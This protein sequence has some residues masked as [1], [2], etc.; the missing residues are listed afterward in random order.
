[1]S[2]VALAINGGNWIA[3]ETDAQLQFSPDQISNMLA[4]LQ[5]LL[6]EGELTLEAGKLHFPT[7]QQLLDYIRD[8]KETF[9]NDE[10]EQ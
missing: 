2:E 1:M 10:I 8:V 3:I 7:G 5:E 6:Q 4:F 9:Q